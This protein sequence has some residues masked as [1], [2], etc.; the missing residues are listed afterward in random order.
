M[1]KSLQLYH[2]LRAA[3]WTPDCRA[4]F[5]QQS[6][7]FG[8]LV[9]GE[10][11]QR[12]PPELAEARYPASFLDLPDRASELR[13]SVKTLHPDLDDLRSRFV[14]NWFMDSSSKVI[15]HNSEQHLFA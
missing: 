6:L 3:H 7:E 11:R 10:R 14:Q 15:T 5:G 1:Q 4:A 13:F 12:L 9:R 8:S 2:A